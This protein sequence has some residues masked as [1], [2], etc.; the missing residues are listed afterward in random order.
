M[1]ELS[2]ILVTHQL[3]LEPHSECKQI[4]NVV[5][6][7]VS[8]NL[9]LFPATTICTRIFE[10]RPKLHGRGGRYFRHVLKSGGTRKRKDA[11]SIG[12]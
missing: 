8:Y 12:Q 7:H 1:Y 4:A 5:N 3:D 11:R 2:W 6:P 9:D 10:F